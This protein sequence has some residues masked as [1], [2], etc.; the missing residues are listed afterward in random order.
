MGQTHSDGIVEQ[1]ATAR[2]E[3]NGL[4]AYYIPNEAGEVDLSN[5]DEKNT[6]QHSDVVSFTREGNSQRDPSRR[7]IYWALLQERVSNEDVGRPLTYDTQILETESP[8]DIQ[9]PWTVAL[10]TNKAVYAAYLAAHG[11][12]NSFL[13][14]ALGV[15]T[16]TVSQYLSDF[17]SERR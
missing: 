15:S 9:I 2:V 11:K 8:E 16:S 1:F 7:A 6:S 13:A 12:S 5:S 14:D 10:T 17:K 4:T 3:Q